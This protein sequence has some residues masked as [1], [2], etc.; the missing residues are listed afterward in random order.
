MQRGSPTLRAQHTARL[1][2]NQI[3]TQNSANFDRPAPV[4]AIGPT[5]QTAACTML[6]QL[7]LLLG[8][9]R[10]TPV[11]RSQ[12]CCAVLEDLCKHTLQVISL[13]GP[14][15]HAVCSAD[16]VIVATCSIPDTLLSL[17]YLLIHYLHT[18]NLQVKVTRKFGC[19][20]SS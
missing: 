4:Y 1:I 8:Y 5:L 14:P 20:L 11:A 2:C 9:A 3:C 16:I 15:L 13:Y 10:P 17:F 6:A 19:C 18:C 7:A 12:S